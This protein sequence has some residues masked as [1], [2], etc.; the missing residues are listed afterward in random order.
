L[1]K[2]ISFWQERINGLF[3]GK[4]AFRLKSQSVCSSFGIKMTKLDVATYTTRI[5]QGVSA[6]SL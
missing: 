4:N 3:H 6:I 2:S 5:V 1:S